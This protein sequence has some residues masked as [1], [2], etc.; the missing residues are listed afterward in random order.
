MISRPVI[1]V[2]VK[3]LSSGAGVVSVTSGDGVESEASGAG[4]GFVTSVGVFP[5]PVI[6]ANTRSR[7]RIM[8]EILRSFIFETPLS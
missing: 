6:E 4:V 2:I 3:D 1:S 7:A 5:Q 8:I